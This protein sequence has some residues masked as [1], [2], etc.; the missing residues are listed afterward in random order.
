LSDASNEVVREVTIRNETGLHLRP[1][2]QFVDVASRYRSAITVRNVTRNSEVVD[3]KSAMQMVL[4]EAAKG[5]VL[6]IVAQGDDALEAVEA[7]IALVERGF[8]M[9]KTE[10]SDKPA[11]DIPGDQTS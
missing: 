7:L 5:C 11:D 3:G 9:V 2:T 6:R 10:S 1:V 8:P 4:L